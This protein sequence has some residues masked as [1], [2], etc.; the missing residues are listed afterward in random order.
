MALGKEPSCSCP[1]KLQSP[2]HLFS[3]AA[4]WASSSDLMSKT[5]L[6]CGPALITMEVIDDCCFARLDPGLLP[7]NPPRRLRANIISRKD[8]HGPTNLREEACPFPLDMPL[9]PMPLD[10]TGFGCAITG[11][12]AVSNAPSKCRSAKHCET[13]CKNLT[14]IILIGINIDEIIGAPWIAVV[15]LGR[16]IYPL[17][18]QCCSNH[19]SWNL[20]GTQLQAF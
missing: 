20:V 14:P 2:N 16:L 8:G 19:T 9:N 7:M 18:C 4:R 17:V 1:P 15:V 6:A 13:L 10:T 11:G 5:P 12:G 3:Q